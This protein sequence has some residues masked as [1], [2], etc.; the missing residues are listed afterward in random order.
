[1]TETCI[2]CGA[3]S[4]AHPWVAVMHQRDAGRALP[5]SARGFVAAP[6]C[7]RCQRQPEHRTQTIKGAFFRRQEAGVA[8]QYA[9]RSDLRL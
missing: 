7:D 3:I 6:C 8:V 1:M 9:G 4:A 5:A 2:G